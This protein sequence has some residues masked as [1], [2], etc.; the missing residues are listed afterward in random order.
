MYILYLRRR[1]LAELQLWQT[2]LAEPVEYLPSAQLLHPPVLLQAYCPLPH[3]VH[4]LRPKPKPK[5][6]SCWPCLPDGQFLQLDC[7]WFSLYVPTG[8]AAQV[9]GDLW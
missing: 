6:D 3:E 1:A 2:L 9:V 4:N 7:P 5:P 8:Q